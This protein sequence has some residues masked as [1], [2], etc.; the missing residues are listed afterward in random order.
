MSIKLLNCGMVYDSLIYITVINKH[1]SSSVTS[2]VKG[3]IYFSPVKG[4]QSFLTICVCVN[5]TVGNDDD[6]DESCSH[7]HFQPLGSHIHK[8]LKKTGP[9]YW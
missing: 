2:H 4:A 1:V 5:P 8:L 6:N 9:L 7:H 3:T